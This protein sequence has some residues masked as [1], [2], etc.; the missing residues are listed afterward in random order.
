MKIYTWDAHGFTSNK[1][2]VVSELILFTDFIFQTENW[3]DVEPTNDWE[4]ANATSI[5]ADG[6]NRTVGGVAVL[7]NKATPFKHIG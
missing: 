7:S 2:Q 5:N 3:S 6:T 1:T 4:A